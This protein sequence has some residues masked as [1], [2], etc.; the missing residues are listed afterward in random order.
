MKH[1]YKPSPKG[2]ANL[3]KKIITIAAIMPGLALTSFGAV[4]PSVALAV[5]GP[6]CETI[7]LVSG[8]DTQTA[9][10][11][12]SE[13][14]DELDPTSYSGGAFTAASETTTVIPPWVDSATEIDL[15]DAAWIS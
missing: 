9:G 8:T 11:A 12:T 4:L 6:T 10:L 3:V 13:P 2:A 14:G 1:A 5:E 7:T 15:T